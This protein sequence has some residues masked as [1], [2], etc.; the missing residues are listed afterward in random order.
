M[1]YVN[2]IWDF[3][4]TLFNTYPRMAASFRM[5]LANLGVSA[6]FDEVMRRLKRSFG[7]AVTHFSDANRLDCDALR[8]RYA[9]I[10]RGLD[11]NSIVPYEG[12]YELLRDV[13]QSGRRNFLYTHRDHVALDALARHDMDKF[14]TGF[15]TADDSFPSK[16]APDAILSILERFDVDPETALMLGDRDID[17]LAARNAGIDGALFDPEHF[18]DWFENRLRSASIGELRRLLAL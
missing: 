6:D 5:A 9:E 16:P 12:V 3:D 1:Q 14:F 18:Y 4:G 10:E 11:L 8:A 15:V 7:F 2:L 13:V 17:V